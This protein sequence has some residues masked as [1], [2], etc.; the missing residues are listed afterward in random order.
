MMLLGIILNTLK[1]WVMALQEGL[2]HYLING[3]IMYC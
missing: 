1:S 3:T 2:Q